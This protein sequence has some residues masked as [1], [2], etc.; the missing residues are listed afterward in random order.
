MSLFD[1][2]NSNCRLRSKSCERVVNLWNK[3]P[4]SIEEASTVDVFQKRVDEWSLDV[5]Y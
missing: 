3:M 4:S 5:D 1:D 2:E